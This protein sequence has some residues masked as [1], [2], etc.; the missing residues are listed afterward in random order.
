MVPDAAGGLADGLADSPRLERA[1]PRAR[2][3][4]GA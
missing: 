4:A 2:A 3:A 1:A